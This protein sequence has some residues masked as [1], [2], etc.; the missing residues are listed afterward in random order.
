MHS[1]LHLGIGQAHIARSEGHVLEY[2]RTEQLIIRILKHQTYLLPNGPHGGFG[3]GHPVDLEVP[4]PVE[5]GV[6]VQ[7][8][9]GLA[10]A[11]GSHQSQPFPLP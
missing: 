5:Q 4:V 10:R 8:E 6:Q 11:V 9:G 7:E 3:Q 1:T 2:R